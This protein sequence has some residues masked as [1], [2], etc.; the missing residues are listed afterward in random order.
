MTLKILDCEMHASQLLAYLD[1]PDQHPAVEVH[2]ATCRACRAKLAR[3]SQAVLAPQTDPL[4]CSECQAGLPEYVQAQTEGK[5]AARLFPEVRAHLTLCPH[6]QRLYQELLEIDDL[7]STGTLPKPVA[8]RQPDLT[9]LR[10]VRVPEGFGE[11]LRRG[12]YWAQS[13]TQALLVDMKAFTSAALSTSFQVPGRQPALAFQPV[14]REAYE[15]RKILYQIALGPENLEKLD[16]DV[17]VYEQPEQPGVVRVVIHV[18]VPGQ[19]LTG[20][21]GSRVQMK[22]D[23]ATRQARTDEGGLAVFEEVSLAELEEAT[24]IIIPPSVQ[25]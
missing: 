21:A 7:T 9:F 22:T 24:F 14:R 4:T 16:V 13:R 17:T 5:D 3:L 25:A 6:C 15:P 2:L 19:L 18:K 23:K 20:F 8:Y 12:A 10:R 11:V 1:A